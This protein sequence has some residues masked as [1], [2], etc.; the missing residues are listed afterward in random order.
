LFFHS[1]KHIITRMKKLMTITVL[2]NLITPNSF[3]HVTVDSSSVRPGDYA[4]LTFRV[5][6]GCDGSATTKISVQLP[7]GILSVKP[8]VHP[9]WTI[10]MN[11][12]ALD[13]PA[14]L[15]GKQVTKRI[16]EVVWSGGVLPDEYMDEFGMSV[17][18][19]ETT[20]P[21]SFPIVQTCEKGTSNWTDIVT[22]EHAFHMA[23]SPAPFI[24]LSGKASH[25]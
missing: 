11:E 22:D 12:T 15:H 8:Q 6:H 13:K 10:A 3:A 19:P 5:P 17:K 23:K 14:T 16:F 25:H 18:L 24:V 20:G 21:L 7:A 9:G 2:L 4:K 1:Q